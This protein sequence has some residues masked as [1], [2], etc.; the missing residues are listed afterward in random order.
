MLRVKAVK[1]AGCMLDGRQL[2]WLVCERFRP[3]REK[4]VIIHGQT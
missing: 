1:K 4:V 3:G 2:V